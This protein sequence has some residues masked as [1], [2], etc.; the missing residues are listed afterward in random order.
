[1][2]KLNIK[3]SFKELIHTTEELITEGFLKVDTIKGTVI[4]VENIWKIFDQT[5]K[6]NFIRNMILY[7][8]LK[9]SFDNVDEI[10]DPV[11][12]VFIKD[13]EQKVIH[14]LKVKDNKIEYLNL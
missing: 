4:L 9:N 3:L 8:K 2:K 1:M 13:K 11:L 12:M 10:K 5:G 7:C 14:Y 6:D